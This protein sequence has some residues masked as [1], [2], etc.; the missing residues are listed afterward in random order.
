M[1]EL[2][3]RGEVKVNYFPPI[4]FAFRNKEKSIF[5]PDYPSLSATV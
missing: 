1:Q 3:L 5:I 2:L 4:L